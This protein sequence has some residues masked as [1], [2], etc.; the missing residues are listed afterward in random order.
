MHTV[1]HMIFV[2]V[3]KSVNRLSKNAASHCSELVAVAILV[4]KRTTQVHV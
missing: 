2:T 1:M 4:L 3:K